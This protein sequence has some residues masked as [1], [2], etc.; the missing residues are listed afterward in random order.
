MF[1]SKLRAND[2]VGIITFNHEAQIILEPTL[3][4]ELP[5]NLF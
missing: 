5:K 2:S 4:S 3:K 1:I